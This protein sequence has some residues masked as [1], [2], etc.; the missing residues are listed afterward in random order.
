VGIDVDKISI[1][2]AERNRI[3]RGKNPSSMSFL[4]GNEDIDLSE[5]KPFDLLI[6]YEVLEHLAKPWEAIDKLE[7]WVKPG[8][9]VC[10]TVPFGPWEY[11]SYDNYPYR[12]H[13][14]ELDAHDIRDM[15]GRKKNFR[16]G[17][18]PYGSSPKTGEPFGWINVEYTKEVDAP[19]ETIDMGRKLKLQRPRQSI[20][21]NIIVGPGAENTMRLT[22]ESIKYIADEIV[23]GDC[24]MTENAHIIL[25]E[26]TS[27]GQP[28]WPNVRIIPCSSP[29]EAGFETPRNEALAA[30]RM[31][32][33]LW[34]DTDERLIDPP[35]LNK[36]LHDNIFQGYSIRQHH[37]AC[38]TVFKPDMPV[39][40]F[41][42][43]PNKEGE[44]M[45]FYGMIHE[46]P[47]F[48]VNK[49]PGLSIVIGD[50]HIAHMGYFA[51]S[52]RRER[53]FRNYPLLQKDIIKYPDRLL[54]KHFIC[55]DNM[56]LVMYE[57]QQNGNQVTDEVKKKCRETI[58]IYQKYFLGK[59]GFLEVDTIQYYSNA[60]A[61]LGEGFD[62][63]LQIK[64]DKNEA[65]PNG[66]ER[67]RFLNLEDAEKEIMARARKEIMPFTAKV[68]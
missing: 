34:I 38:D 46:H 3:K 8:G 16:Y 39:R 18:M 14:W 41:R 59:A 47:E 9:E 56:I 63:A 4:A 2:W 66:A 13:V 25:R 45:H 5:Q 37:F 43:R 20:S 29:V 33:I 52:I 35:K 6:M 27:W 7:R 58:E 12:C 62:V 19:C 30:S 51:E 10:I 40:L 64:A 61:L 32:W 31:D 42:N 36:Y 11:E 53:F 55:R 67:I 44:S 65:K 15:F 68:W 54:Q 28:L 21:A 26:T 22:L 50:L 23:I 1:D 17:I 24:G 48:G 57:M 49:G 60:V